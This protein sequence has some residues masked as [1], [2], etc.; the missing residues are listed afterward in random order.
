MERP[1][2]RRVGARPAA[3]S[4]FAGLD[5]EFFRACVDATG[6]ALSHGCPERVLPA[7]HLAATMAPLHEPVQSC[8]VDLL[9]AAGLQAEALTVFDTVRSRLVNDLGIDPGASL[10]AAHHRVLAQT[11]S[12]TSATQPAP[13]SGT[14]AGDTGVPGRLVGRSDEIA[15]VRHALEPTFAARTAVVLL[16]GEPGAGKSRLLEEAAADA[17]ARGALVVRGHCLEG[18]GAHP[19][20]GRGSRRWRDPREPGAGPRGKM[21]RRASSAAWWRRRRLVADAPETGQRR[22]V[23]PER[24]DGRRRRGAAAERPPGGADLDDLQWADLASLDLFGH[25]DGPAAGR[26]HADRRVCARSRPC[27]VPSSPASWPEPAGWPGTVVCCSGRSAAGEVS[28]LVRRETGSDADHETATAGCTAAPGE[29]RSSSG[30]WRACRTAEVAVS[31]RRRRARRA[32][33]GPRRR[34]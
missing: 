9:G 32:R 3:A 24:A 27:P 13:P 15:T 21:A 20:C 16:E 12:S 19:R 17:A 11:R 18:D 2:G 6:V 7:L 4:I 31:R 25:L 14:A 30:S 33:H 5:D 26:G 1:G 10:A 28:E 8:L 23:P 22:P 29:I 34:P